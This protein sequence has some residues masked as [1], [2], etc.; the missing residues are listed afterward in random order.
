MAKVQQVIGVDLNTLAPLLSPH[1]T[2]VP[3]APTGGTGNQIAT[4]TDITN[5]IA[6]VNPAIAVSA[7]TTS[8]ANTSAWTYNNGVA[9][10]GAT[11]TGPVNTAITIDGFTYTTILTQSLLVKNDTQV[12]SGAFNGVYVL[13]TLQTAITGAVFT[14][15]LDYDTPSDINNTGSIPVVNG[16]DIT[17]NKN[18]SW[19]ITSNVTT[20][21][22]DPLTYQQFSYS[23]TV[24][25]R[26]INK[27]IA[28]GYAG[29]D[30]NVQ[31]VI[32]QIPLIRNDFRLTL[33][34]GTPVTI[35]D[36]TYAGAQTL[37]CTPYNGPYIS[38]Y[39]ATN[40]VTYKSNEFFLVLGT[41][42]NVTMYDVFCYASSGVPTLEFLAWTN[43]TTRA[44]ALV[45]QD[46][47]ICK[48]GDT[49]RRYIGTFYNPGNQ[50]ATVTMTIAAPG[51][52]TYAGHGLSANAPVV[53]TT[54]GALPTGIVSGTTY[55]VCSTAVTAMTTNTFQ[56]SATAGGTPI[57]T[58]GSQ[59]G[60]HTCTVPT[61]T[62]DSIANR[63]LW[64]FYNQVSRR[65]HR[66][67]SATN[68]TYTTN[69][70]RQSNASLLN[71]LNFIVGV[72]TNIV[73]AIFGNSRVNTNAG[74]SMVS[75]IGLDSITVGTTSTLGRDIIYQS[76]VSGTVAENV[77]QCFFNDYTGIGKHYLSMLEKST[78]TGTT[79]WNGANSS[80]DALLLG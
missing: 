70:F 21:G 32:A 18:T 43:T 33:T 67:D 74:V 59:S 24:V 76:V 14:R 20:V 15:R 53:F 44:T 58:S 4:N 30:A 69:T 47:I 50:S 54:N 1:F 3:T 40:W 75:E 27:N 36:V 60:T 37:Y 55:Y 12:P 64:N 9:G 22:T 77:G 52:I 57:T 34:S 11:F 31:V 79:T 28:N 2:G 78:A 38:L 65:M 17:G 71:Q 7:A 56:V 51:V 49:T 42:T 46:G 29:L 25:E 5:A 10:I 6:G 62:E 63:Y 80:F 61:Y 13:T 16:T 26:N 73:T 41:L 19:V 66:S 72:E 39:N 45:Y 8:A 68:W 35:A 23:P 48:T